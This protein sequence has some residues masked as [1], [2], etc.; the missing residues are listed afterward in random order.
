MLRLA[1]D[2]AITQRDLR[3]R[4]HRRHDNVGEFSEAPMALWNWGVIWVFAAFSVG[5]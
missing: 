5:F 4:F 2:N 3:R 1:R